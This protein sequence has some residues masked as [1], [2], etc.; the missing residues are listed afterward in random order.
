M[1]KYLLAAAAT[2]ALASPATAR[3]G[4][5][6]VGVDAGAMIVEDA[7]LDFEYDI[8]GITYDYDDAASVDHNTGYDVGL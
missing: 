6:Y 3:D 2:V 4:S 7:E 8:Q 5:F 1:R